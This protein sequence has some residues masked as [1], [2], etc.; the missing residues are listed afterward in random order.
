MYRGFSPRCIFFCPFLEKTSEKIHFRGYFRALSD[1]KTKVVSYRE[2][3]IL[4][5]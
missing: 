5:T 3:V 2:L 1:K 4:C